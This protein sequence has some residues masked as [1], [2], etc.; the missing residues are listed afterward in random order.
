MKKELKTNEIPPSMK[1]WRTL[2]RIEDF[3]ED[4]IDF[5]VP[6]WDHT[7]TVSLDR[8]TLPDFVN[9][10]LN[11]EVK[12]PFRLFAKCNIGTEDKNELMFSDWEIK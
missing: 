7:V 12:L 6:S 9:E 4:K 10:N 5:V 8:N 3:N 1:M 2:I 11:K